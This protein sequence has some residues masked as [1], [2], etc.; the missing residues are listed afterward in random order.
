[1]P[2]LGRF[3]GSQGSAW[4]SDSIRKH[5]VMP[6]SKQRKLEMSIA[7]L[8]PSL[9]LILMGL[10]ADESQWKYCIWAMIFGYTLNGFI[11]PASMNIVDMAPD[12]TGTLMGLTNLSI[13]AFIMPIYAEAITSVHPGDPFGWR[14]I[15]GTG[16][17][18]YVLSTIGFIKYGRFEKQ[19]FNEFH[20][21]SGSE[22]S[23]DDEE[24]ERLI[25][26]S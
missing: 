3:L 18:F 17:V 11:T 26:E 16:S 23:E 24:E 25:I 10:L 13:A 4:L 6:K 22:L 2:Y 8:G 7:L 5:S 19:N 15:F 21:N 14:I 12:L 20:K 9:G 1:M